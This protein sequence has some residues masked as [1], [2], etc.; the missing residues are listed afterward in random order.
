MTMIHAVDAK[1]LY[2]SL[3]AENPS[4]SENATNPTA[5]TTLMHADNLTKNASKRMRLWMACPSVQ[6]RE[7]IRNKQRDDHENNDR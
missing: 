1:S 4:I 7:E 5:S 6:L 2:D 3:I